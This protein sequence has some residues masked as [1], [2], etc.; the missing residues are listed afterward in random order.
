VVSPT[1]E[2]QNDDA[3][4]GRPASFWLE[5]TPE[6]AY[7]AF[8]VAD[9]LSVDTAVVGGGIAGV[10]TAM[11]LKEAGQSVALVERDRVVTGVTGHTSAKLTSLHGLIYDDL[12][13]QFGVSRARLYAEANEAAIDDVETTVEKYDI[14]CNF[15]RTPA[16]TYTESSGAVDR[17][18]DEVRAAER[19][20]L[21]ASFAESTPLPYP[22][23]GAVRF[24]SQARFHPR[25]YLLALA[26]RIPGD[27]SHLFERTR[28]TDVSDG[29]PCRVMTDRGDLL[30]DDVVVATHF[31]VFDHA[32]FFARLEPKYSYV[33][34]ARLAG[35]APEG[36][37]YD[38]TE[39][40]FSVRPRPGGADDMV[41]VGGQ[42]HRTGQGGNTV[43]RYRRLAT[44]A[45]DRFD[46]ESIEYRWST[47][48]FTSLD[49]VPFVGRHSP[50]VDN[51][52]VAT[53]FGGWGMTGGTVAGMLLADLVRRRENPW[54]EVYRPTRFDLD[55][56]KGRLA[57]HT[58]ETAKE[59]LQDYVT[60]RPQKRRVRLDPGEATVTD[61]DDGPVGVHR[62]ETGEYHAVS[63]V[64]PHM[65]C[66]VE[67]N[68]GERSWDCPCHGSRFDADGVVINAPAVDD[69]PR[70]EYPIRRGRD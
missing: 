41:L 70:R 12:V 17:I 38:P 51:V 54:R 6:T 45:R 23:E 29:E 65:G 4:E 30:A 13:D 14:D 49:R 28:V 34:A 44:E 48:D 36:M 39:P 52:F 63:A 66:L 58:K 8:D 20:G 61:T 46:V 33:V 57:S 59:Y 69:L 1:R 64:C 55:A 11:K 25:A 32:L 15:A 27:G 19:L 2:T 62:D 47:E 9:T 5:T 16:Y 21:P 35:E 40:Y 42:G 60:N 50:Q 26:E 53:G 7:D 3:S 56:S 37:Y 31:P 68:P 67:W 22:V 10:T 24:D 18:R 43:E